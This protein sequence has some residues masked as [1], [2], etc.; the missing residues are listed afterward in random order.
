MVASFAIFI[1]PCRLPFA[2]N[3]LEHWARAVPRR[4]RETG[5]GGFHP[6]PLVAN[7]YALSLDDFPAR[8][9]AGGRLAAGGQDLH[10]GGIGDVVVFRE[11]REEFAA[12]TEMFRC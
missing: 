7:S 1:H 8:P 11:S 12:V 9:G 5:G 3:A 2:P 6:A 4:Q 10:L